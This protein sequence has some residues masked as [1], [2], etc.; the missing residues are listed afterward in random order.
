LKSP[1]RKAR[2]IFAGNQGDLQGK[3]KN[4][5]EENAERHQKKGEQPRKKESALLTLGVDAW[6]KIGKKKA[7]R[8]LGAK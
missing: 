8:D 4:S 1:I 2:P 3:Q 5:R 6:I 7:A